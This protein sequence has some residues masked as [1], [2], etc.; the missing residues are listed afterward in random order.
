MDLHSN[1]H[2]YCHAF[3]CDRC[4]N[5]LLHSPHAS[6][7]FHQCLRS[8]QHVHVRAK[9]KTLQ[10]FP[11]CLLLQGWTSSVSA[12]PSVQEV[13]ALVLAWPSPQTD[14]SMAVDRPC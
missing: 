8:S 12:W 11:E 2:Q 10:C 6:Q 9:S 7:P 5:G 3:A 14:S 13:A 1:R 4:S